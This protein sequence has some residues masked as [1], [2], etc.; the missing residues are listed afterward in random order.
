MKPG[1]TDGRRAGIDEHGLADSP[2]YG[3][4]P[5]KAAACFT[6]VAIRAWSS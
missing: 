6:Q 5:G 4:H 1:P 2:G 3:T